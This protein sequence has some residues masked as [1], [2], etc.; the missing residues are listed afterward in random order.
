M[1]YRILGPFEVSD[2]G[3]GI[4]IG[5][6]KPRALLAV[7][8]LH[9]NEVVSPDVLID[10]LWG[11][12]P[13]ATAVK[14]LQAHV[15]RLRKAL[16]GEADASTHGTGVLRTSGRGYLLRVEP[17]QLDADRVRDMVDEAR[18]ARHDGKPEQAAEDLRRAL[19]LWRGPAL[20]DFAYESFA[21]T[22]IARL[23]EL[24]LT[25]LEERIEA[26]LALGRTASS[27][28]SSSRSWPGTRL[29]ERPRGQLDAR[30]LPLGPPG[31]GAARLPGGSTA[32]AG[33][34]RARAERR[35]CSGSSAASSSRIPCSLAPARA[36]QTADRPAR[37]PAVIRARSSSPAS[38]SS[39]PP[40]APAC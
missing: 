1:E 27:S 30:A 13:P 37:R 3:R 6:P 35:A 40:W 28:A 14:T 5:G 9:A 17:D 7:L 19:A 39:P 18:R 33:E 25:A 24:Q 36:S 12:T 10:E 32:L 8:L 23:D 20:A 21:Q 16:N 22:E 31:R 29:R 26:D 11:E 2:N 15:S 38:P 4:E 34:A